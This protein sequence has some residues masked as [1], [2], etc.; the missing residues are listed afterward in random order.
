MAK[1]ENKYERRAPSKDPYDTV[2]IVCE[3]E[4]TEKNY[5]ESMIFDLKLNSAN[6]KVTPASGPDP[7]T[8]AEYA[9]D[10]LEEYDKVFCVFDRDTHSRF[11]AAVEKIRQSKEGRSGKWVAIT[12]TPCFELWL[13][14]HFHFHTAPISQT[15][16]TSPGNIACSILDK[17]MQH[18]LNVGYQK[19]SRGIYSL[20]K[21]MMP[22]AISNAKRLT[23]S[24]EDTN[25]SNPHTDMQILV[26]YLRA[27]KG[28]R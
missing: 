16:K 23:K 8:V 2:L 14:L 3:G 27:L 22:L 24:N 26:E 1:K 12:S 9:Q 5:F 11:S 19:N 18:T 15:G 25:S 17:H 7:L 21:S 13:I 10:F 6:I 20:L 4:K 28:P